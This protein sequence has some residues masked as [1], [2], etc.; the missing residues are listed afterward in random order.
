LHPGQIILV[1]NGA[2]ETLSEGEPHGSIGRQRMHG[3][4]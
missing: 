1:W 2:R 4:R 3:D